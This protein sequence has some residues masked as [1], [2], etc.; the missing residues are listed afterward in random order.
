MTILFLCI[1][2]K[3]KCHQVLGNNQV[4]A[5]KVGTIPAFHM[6]WME[7]QTIILPSRI[8]TYSKYCFKNPILEEL[9]NL[10]K[11]F[12]FI[13]LTLSVVRSR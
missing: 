8:R 4:I 11:A 13:C 6:S 5:T 1:G 2:Q 12:I 3:E 10:A 9:L 7:I